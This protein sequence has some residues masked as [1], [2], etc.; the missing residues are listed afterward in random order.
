LK[1]NRKICRLLLW[2]GAGILAATVVS[3]IPLWI[4]GVT[5]RDYIEGAW[6]LLRDPGSTR[7]RTLW[8]FLKSIERAD[9]LVF[10][11]C[12]FYLWEKRKKFE[13]QKIPIAGL[14]AWMTFSLFG[15]HA[16]G[17]YHRH[18]FKLILPPLALAAGFGPVLTYDMFDK[19]VRSQQQLSRVTGN[20]ALEAIPFFVAAAHAL[21]WCCQKCAYSVAWQAQHDCAGYSPFFSAMRCA[22]VA[23]WFEYAG[24]AVCRQCLNRLR[25]CA[26][27]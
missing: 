3:L 5:I 19:S 9:S 20:L 15:V 12:L 26:V 17:W 21:S 18:N 24:L 1:N 16:Q 8:R 2:L 11:I 7:P 13:D 25:S 10:F 27:E 4:S 23:Q 14:L 22:L 6:L